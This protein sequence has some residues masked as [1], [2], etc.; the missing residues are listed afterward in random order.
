M[1][2]DIMSRTVLCPV[3]LLASYSLQASLSCML[4]QENGTKVQFTNTSSASEAAR[5]ITKI[6][7]SFG[8]KTEFE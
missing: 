7:K 6:L 1:R 2:Y 4:M 8:F 3:V 5:T